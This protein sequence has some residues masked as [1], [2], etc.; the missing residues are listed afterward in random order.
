V[1][2]APRLT[3]APHH[4]TSNG[5]AEKVEMPPVEPHIASLLHRRASRNLNVLGEEQE[6]TLGQRMADRLTMAAGSWT[7]IIIFLV[8]I[9]IWMAINAVAWLHHWDPYPFILL[10]LVLSCIAAIQ[11]PVILMSQNREE[12]RDRLRAQADYEVNLKAELLLEHLTEEIEALKA[13]L[14]EQQGGF[15]GDPAAALAAEAGAAQDGLR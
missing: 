6:K 2:A 12:A 3:P 10:N 5:S 15:A 1:G 7:F 4:P 8:I 13:F 11:A 9:A 14:M